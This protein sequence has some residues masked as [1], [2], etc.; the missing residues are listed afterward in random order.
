MAVGALARMT[1]GG[2]GDMLWLL[3]L[4]AQA[5]LGLR[6]LLRL[7][8]TARGQRIVAVDR[9]PEA[10]ESVSVLL[11]VLNERRRLGPCLD[12]LLAQGPELCEIVVIDGGSGDGTQNLVAAYGGRDQRVRLVDASVIPPGWN[13]KAWGLQV[14][15]E[16]A[17]LT[18]TWVLTMDA[19]VRP[20]PGLVASLVAHA[21]RAGLGVVSV[22]TTQ[23][24]AGPGSALVHPALLATLV[25]RFGIPG[26][27]ACRPETVQANGQCLLIRRDLLAKIGGF[28]A[29]RRSLCDD[30]TVARRLATIGYPSGFFEAPGLVSVRMYESGWETFVNWSRSLPLRDHLSDSRALLGLTEVGLVQALPLAVVLSLRNER[31]GWVGRWLR[32]VNLGLVLLR[33]GTLAGTRRAYPQ[34]PWTFWL[35]P[36][37]DVPITVMLWRSALTRRH[38]WR[39]REVSR[40]AVA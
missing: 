1:V 37:L 3:L 33:L 15:L 10:D 25:Y 5:T 22:A 13:G 35:S 26:H 20:K 14:G 18:T 32:A 17:A 40:G 7:L 27:V 9:Y 36:L 19:D 23:E 39:G 12:G 24:L 29:G 34:A 11:P 38:R 21:E 6:V 4:I 31:A 30:V 16:Q 28:A 2:L 8:R